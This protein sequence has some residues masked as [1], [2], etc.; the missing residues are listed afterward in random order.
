MDRTT[1]ILH[2]IRWAVYEYRVSP[3]NLGAFLT[4][5]GRWRHH[6]SLI[7]KEE[8][9]VLS[10]LK[11]LGIDLVRPP[12]DSWVAYSD[13]I[14]H[15]VY[16]EFRDFQPHGIVLDVGAQYGDYA[17]LAAR[18]Y[19]AVVHTFE[20][21]PS[22][23]ELLVQNVTL[24]GLQSQVIAHNQAVGNSVGSTS[25]SFDNTMAIVGGSKT[26]NVQAITIDSLKLTPT[27]MKIDVEG[28]EMDVLNGARETLIG[29][30]PMVIVETH[31]KDLRRQVD[32][33]MD[34]LGYR[35]VHVNCK[36]RGE[37]WMDEKMNRFYHCHC[38]LNDKGNI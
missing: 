1:S 20:P 36:F 38:T 6:L 8:E 29:S 37:G 9:G 13:V 26:V 12:V 30:R 17:V 15:E 3:Y 34:A 19:G 31:S 18:K 11:S 23:F 22:N 27:L 7:H 5:D 4:K 32:K 2:Q 35:C 10:S 21:L 24:N 14:F 28:M 25:I 33:F 16:T